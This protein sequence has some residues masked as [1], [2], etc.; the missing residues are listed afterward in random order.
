MPET[1]I[2]LSEYRGMW[3]FVLFDLPVDTAAK[4]KQYTRFRKQ[5]LKQGFSMLQ[6]SVYAR[7]FAS[8]DGANIHKMRVREALPPEGQ[9]RLLSVTDKQFGKMEVFFG[10]N[11][12]PTEDPPMQLSLF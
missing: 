1:R 7:Y 11:R 10:I 9:V 6:Y 4:R 5:L 8:E 2:E 12:E 3:L